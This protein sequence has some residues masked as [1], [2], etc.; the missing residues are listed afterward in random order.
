[1]KWSQTVFPKILGGVF[2]VCTPAIASDYTS[3]LKAARQAGYIQSGLKQK[4]D[5]TKRYYAN[6][7]KSRLTEY[8]LIEETAI[9]GTTLELIQNKAINIRYQGVDY[10]VTPNGIKICY[11]F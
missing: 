11:Y 4:V 8:G 5:S 9:L 1:V 2:C 7:T 10:F 6:L 3:A